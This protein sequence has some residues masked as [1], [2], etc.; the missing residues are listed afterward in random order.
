MRRC[1]SEAVEAAMK[2]LGRTEHGPS[3]TL[4]RPPGNAVE[5]NKLQIGREPLAGKPAKV[6]GDVLSSQTNGKMDPVNS[7]LD[8]ALEGLEEMLQSYGLTPENLELSHQDELIKQIEFGDMNSEL[9]PSSSPNN[10]PATVES[11]SGN[12]SFYVEHSLLTHGSGDWHSVQSC[13][14]CSS[15]RNN[16]MATT[17]VVSPSSQLFLPE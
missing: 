9:I 13:L 3:K 4:T 15:N 12:I 2:C 6:D 10:L 5:R 8:V 7:S 16:S 11:L 14:P 17:N 1:V